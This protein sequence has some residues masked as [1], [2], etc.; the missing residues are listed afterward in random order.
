MDQHETAVR[1]LLAAARIPV[2][3]TE[4]AA[5][6]GALPGVQAGVEALYA[7]PEARYVDPALRFRAETA[8][9]DW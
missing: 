4:I 6:A 2:G 5:A 7:I 3:E 9:V 1:E 8:D